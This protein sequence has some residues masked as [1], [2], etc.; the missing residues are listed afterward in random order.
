MTARTSLS[1]PLQ[2]AEVSAPGATGAIG[3]TF[4]PGKK[5]RSAMSGVWDRDLGLDLDAIKA[6]GAS[7]IIT[8]IEPHE[9]RDLKVERIDEQTEHRGMEWLHM[10]IT[11]I[12]TPDQRFEMAWRQHG[13]RLI[14]RVR[15]GDRVLVHCKGGL[16]RAGTVAA[17]M[18]VELGMVP[19]DAISAVRLVRS[20]DAIETPS[21]ERY[22]HAWA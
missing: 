14:D 2:I 16:G 11:D 8:L 17:L 5:Q 1:H 22:I 6:W 19:D 18:L 12:S 10:P 21:Q 13:A 9:I 15:T 7:A 20:R 4:C 3:I